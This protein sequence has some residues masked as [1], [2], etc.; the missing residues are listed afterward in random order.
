MLNRLLI[1]MIVVNH[2][3]KIAT[4]YDLIPNNRSFVE[5]IKLISAVPHHFIG[6]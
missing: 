5:Y 3:M 4:E 6:N 1:L 2:T